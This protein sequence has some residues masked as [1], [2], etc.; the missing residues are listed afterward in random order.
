MRP[1]SFTVTGSAGGPTFS[2]AFPIDVQNNPTC[3]GIAVVVSGPLAIA[4]VQHTFANPWS[5]NL[6][7][8][9]AA[10]WINNATL[11]SATEANNPN[12]A[13]DTNYA[14][15]PTALRL[16]VRALASAGAG[17]RATI[18]IIQAGPE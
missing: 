3:I 15:P 13:T 12:G 4:D 6:N 10:A 11:V 14:F 18:T 9:S 17:E 7:T 2:P 5:I 1:K 8:V 16:R